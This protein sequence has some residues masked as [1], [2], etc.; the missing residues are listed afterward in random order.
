VA[1]TVR[2]C[3]AVPLEDT[4]VETSTREVDPVVFWALTPKI[5]ALIVPAAFGFTRTVAP[6]RIELVP[7]AP[8]ING[9]SIGNIR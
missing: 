9:N 4:A 5:R 1:G 6:V 7:A 8:V 3:S 2:I